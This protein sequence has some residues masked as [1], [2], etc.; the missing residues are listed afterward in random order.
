MESA[1]EK[2]ADV[3]RAF[4]FDARLYNIIYQRKSCG[5]SLA[6]PFGFMLV[7]A[8]TCSCSYLLTTAR[9]NRI[10]IHTGADCGKCIAE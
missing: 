1:L 10:F 9:T 6:Y 2:F 4:Y 8:P 7:L 5:E 3:E